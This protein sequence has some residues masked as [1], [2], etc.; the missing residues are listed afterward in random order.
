MNPS[1]PE[2]FDRQ[3]RFAS[4]GARGQERLSAARVLLVGTGA[5]GGVLAQTLVRAGVGQLVLADRDIVERSNLPRQVLFEDQHAEAGEAKVVAA[6]MSLERIGG[7]TRLECHAVHVDGRNLAELAAGCDLILDGTDNLA[8]RYLINDFSIQQ[9]IPWIYGG[10]VGGAGLVLPV[11]P[12]KGPCLRCVFR[13]PPP[14][15]SLPTCDTAGVIL[16]AVSLVASMQAGLALRILGG[17][18]LP[19][20]GLIELD[21]WNGEVRRLEARPD[22]TCPCCGLGKFEFWDQSQGDETLTLCGRN[23]VQVHRPGPAPDLDAIAARLAG[24]A[25][26]IQRAGPLLRA[27]VDDLVLTVFPDGRTLIEGTDDPQRA[28]GIFDRWIGG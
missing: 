25:T 1:Q 21:A 8:T 23:T 7:P 16:P 18:D 14:P 2:R 20:P 24:V 19:K 4:L 5:L 13:T 3:I 6:R 9:G 17:S 10:V 28:Q 11:L 22:P 12:G 27:E 15:G 26:R